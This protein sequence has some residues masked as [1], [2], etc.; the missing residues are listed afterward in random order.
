VDGDADDGRCRVGGVDPFM[1]LGK[2][3]AHGGSVRK[4][5]E[6]EGFEKGQRAL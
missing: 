3:D 4:W 5:E 1:V 2:L 6:K